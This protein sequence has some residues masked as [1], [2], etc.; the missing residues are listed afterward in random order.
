LFTALNKIVFCRLWQ[1]P[2]LIDDLELNIAYGE[3]Y[4]V[5]VYY[6]VMEKHKTLPPN[7]AKGFHSFDEVKQW[8]EK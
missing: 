4:G 2:I 8:M 6:P 3:K 1:I 7:S 5:A